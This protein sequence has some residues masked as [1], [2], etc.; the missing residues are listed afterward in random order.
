MKAL[1]APGGPWGG[2]QLPAALHRPVPPIQTRSAAFAKVVKSMAAPTI[3]SLVREFV[4]KRLTGFIMGK[5]K[6]LNC[7]RLRSSARLKG[8]I[9]TRIE[10]SRRGIDEREAV[11]HG[12]VRA[13]G[14]P[15]EQVGRALDDVGSTGRN[16]T[17]CELKL[18][19]CP[20]HR[21]QEAGG[22]A[23]GCS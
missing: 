4:F 11:A 3:A 19:I 5:G 23:C 7:R 18:A 1:A 20:E 14:G 8:A 9:E 22:R 17:E 21:S 15:T 13:D 2:P 16:F 10:I 6:G 12:D